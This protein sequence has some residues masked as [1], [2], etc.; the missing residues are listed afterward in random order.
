MSS[1]KAFSP[2]IL[3][4][5]EFPWTSDAIYLNAAGIGPLPERSRRAVEDF[6]ALRA[7]PHRLSDKM[8]YATLAESRRLAAAF[9]TVAARKTST[10]SGFT[11]TWTWTMN[12][13][14]F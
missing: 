12:M 8:L 10:A 3:R 7:A 13:K 4:S 9:C 6:A 14:T 11:R 2:L 1:E 5:A